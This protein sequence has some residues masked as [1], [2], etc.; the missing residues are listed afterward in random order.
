MSLISLL[1]FLINLHQWTG[2]PIFPY[3]VLSHLRIHHV[4]AVCIF[5]IFP[6]S[7]LFHYAYTSLLSVFFHYTYKFIEL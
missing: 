7:V 2:T 6:Y 4:I 5:P 1:M 3:F